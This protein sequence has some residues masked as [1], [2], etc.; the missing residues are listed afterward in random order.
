MDMS[1]ELAIQKIYDALF[2]R[3]GKQHWWP[4]QTQLEMIL[5]AILTQNT[6]WTNVDKAISNLRQAGALN[7]NV[8]EKASQEQIGEWIRPAGYFNQKAKCIKNVIHVISDQYNGSLNQLFLLDTPTLRKE[9]LAWK[10]IG[11]ETADC[12]LLYAANRPVF[13][14]DAYTKRFLARHG[15]CE[16]K[17]S[18]DTIGRL[19]TGALPPDAA[20]FNEYHALIVQLGKEH[21]KTKPQCKGCPLEDF[22]FPPT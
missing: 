3:W 22:L 11:P 12:I 21:C 6:A 18:Y 7:L 2:A 16:P 15:L 13:V 4:A 20:L 14:V 10:G 17:T 9:L 5:G 19:F 8:L 1:P